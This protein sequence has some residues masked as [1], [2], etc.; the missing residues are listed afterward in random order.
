M[1]SLLAGARFYSV[2]ENFSLDV[3]NDP[4]LTVRADFKIERPPI[5]SCA[6]RWCC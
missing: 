1:A 5:A 2:E 6:M 3:G 4:K